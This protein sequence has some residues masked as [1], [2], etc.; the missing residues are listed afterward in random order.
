M[1]WK[2]PFLAVA[3]SS[4]ALRFLFAPQDAAAAARLR[5]SLLGAVTLFYVAQTP[6]PLLAAS[7]CDA[8]AA[9]LWC[10]VAA[11]AWATGGCPDH[12][13]APHPSASRRSARWGRRQGAVYIG[14]DPA[15]LHGP[16]A[17]VDPRLNP[18]WM[19]HVEEMQPL[20][21]E[22]LS[23]HSNP[24]AAAL[25]P[26]ALGAA[27]WVWLGWRKAGRTPA[28]LLL[29]A[30]LGAAIPIALGAQ[31]ISYY[32]E[33][34][35]L[36]VMAAALGDIATRYWKSSPVPG[37]ALAALFS[38]PVLIAALDAIPGWERS[39]D[40]AKISA[41]TQI[42]TLR[43]LANLPPGLV[44]ADI[45]LGA[46]VLAATPDAVM[47][48]PYHRMTWGILSANHALAASPGEDERA[49]RALGVTYVLNCPAQAAHFT[50]QMMGPQSLQQRLDRSAVPAWLEPLSAKSDPLQ[51]Y[52][53]RPS[54]P[55]AWRRSSTYT[56]APRRY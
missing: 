17:A 9:N 4:F 51:V 33:W 24:A 25:A 15:C 49:T 52:R 3:G 23:Q 29:G 50:H 31:R 39:A 16:L 28:W 27:S 54:T 46:Y 10:A 43:P 47:A 21:K 5:R 1:A 48:A 36:P 44:L 20:L 53:V 22:A 37:V 38:Q 7:V 56:P 32:A 12:A 18:I 41:C 8:L 14:L 11:A 40:T 2:L 55:L 30:M 13:P 6:P 26:I 35:A 34:F 42:P 19:D 45:D